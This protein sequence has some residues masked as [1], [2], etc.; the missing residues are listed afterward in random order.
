MCNSELIQCAPAYS[1]CSFVCNWSR[2]ALWG[3]GAGLWGLLCQSVSPQL[4]WPVGSR[5]VSAGH[6]SSRY[7]RFSDLCCNTHMKRGIWVCLCA[8]G[9]RCQDGRLL[10]DGG[11]VRLDECRCG[12]P[13]EN[14]TL[15]IRPGENVTVS[16]NTWWEQLLYL[17][18]RFTLK[19]V[20]GGRVCQILLTSGDI[21]LK[22]CPEGKET[23]NRIAQMHTNS[24]WHLLFWSHFY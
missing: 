15:E 6:L 8:A 10:Q 23:L 2:W 16:C 21:C 24:Y 19:D 4:R 22:Y 13:L 3:Q 11:C 20:P 7:Q 9:C 14:G 18:I 17:C 5:P 1:S 12:L